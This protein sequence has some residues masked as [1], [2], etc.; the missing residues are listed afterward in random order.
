MKAPVADL[1]ATLSRHHADLDRLFERLLEAVRANARPDIDTLW[2]EFDAGLRKHFAVEEALIL[3]RF[4]AIDRS[5]ADALLREHDEMRKALDGFAI[6]VDLHLTRADVVD[7][8]V[9]RLRAHAARED[10][11]LYEWA[12]ANLPDASQT[13]VRERL[14]GALRSLAD[15]LV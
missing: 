4:K 10:R 12:E 5:E 7:D 11:L 6:E 3:P 8:F 2:T 1:A 13:S 15:K 14:A 9:A